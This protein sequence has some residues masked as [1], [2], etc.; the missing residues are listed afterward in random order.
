MKCKWICLFFIFPFCVKA[1]LIRAPQTP[2]EEFQ[3]YL[4]TEE[5]TSYSQFQLQEIQKQSESSKSLSFLLEQ[6]QRSFLKGHLK[7][8]GDYFRSITKQAY[9]NDWNKEIKNMIFYSYLRLAQIE[10]KDDPHNFLY[11]AIIFSPSFKPDESLFPPPLVKKFNEIKTKQPLL[12]IK[13]R[14]IFPFHKTILINGTEMTKSTQSLPYGNY[15]VT[16][17]SSSHQP[18]SQKISLSE[19]VQKR[20]VT[21]PWAGGSC[22][23]PFVSQKINKENV[24][25]PQFCRWKPAPIVKKKETLPNLVIENNMKQKIQMTLKDNQKWVWVGAAVGI[26]AGII[27]LNKNKTPAPIIKKGF[28]KN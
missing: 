16:A 25:Y 24:L 12:K 9:S 26:T 5:M 2:Y 4:E 19:L 7:Q 11:S 1:Q 20:I 27:L 13:L 18:W 15:R 8:S 6:A 28:P 21:P 17:L 14:R 3:A 10:W 22:Q 23:K